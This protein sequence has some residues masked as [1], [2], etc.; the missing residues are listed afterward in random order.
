[1]ADALHLRLLTDRVRTWNRWYRQ[2]S[3]I[4]PDF[5]VAA[6]S[7]AQLHA[8]QLSQADFHQAILS[9]VLLSQANLRHADLRGADLHGANV[10]HAD[11]SFADLTDADLSH[12]NLSYV[13]LNHTLFKETNHSIARI[14]G[15]IRQSFNYALK[16]LGWRA[17]FSFARS[18]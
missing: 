7:G 11:L 12:A 14:F 9:H 8:A 10:V 4:R 3:H 13:N 18:L 1:M 17:S 5:G 15:V 16:V 2:H 6:L